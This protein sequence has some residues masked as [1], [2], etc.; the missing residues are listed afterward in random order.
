MHRG[1]TAMS[2]RLALCRP[3]R[4]R[5]FMSARI[6]ALVC[7]WRSC[8]T[9][10]KHCRLCV[11]CAFWEQ[12]FRIAAASCRDGPC[13]AEMQ[14]LSKLGAEGDN[15]NMCWRDLKRHL[16]ESECWMPDPVPVCIFILDPTAFE[17]NVIWISWHVILVQ[18]IFHAYYINDRDGF[19]RRFLGG[20]VSKVKEYWM[21]TRPDDPRFVNHPMKANANWTTAAIPARI[22]GDGVPYGKGRHASVDAV[23][24]S[25]KLSGGHVLDWL[26]LWCG[27]P[28]SALCKKAEHG[29]DTEEWL[30]RALAYD[31]H[32]CIT[33]R[34]HVYYWGGEVWPS[35]MQRSRVSGDVVGIHARRC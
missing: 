16:G 22:H 27:V 3:T 4:A 5:S 8:D 1:Q 7:T 18:E 26:N 9:R 21:Q 6:V 20:D 17:D 25:S 15:P 12:P 23:S 34:F 28:K 10:R 11:A 2:V 32:C 35:W 13:D 24:W 33:G 31:M 19:N 30:W 29:Y 14:M